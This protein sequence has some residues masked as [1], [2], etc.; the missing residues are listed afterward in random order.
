MKE[1]VTDDSVT[2]SRKYDVEVQTNFKILPIR[3]WLLKRLN[4][5]LN[6]FK[7]SMKTCNFIQITKCFE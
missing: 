4:E 2:L 5:F 6:K 3:W 7:V 1:E